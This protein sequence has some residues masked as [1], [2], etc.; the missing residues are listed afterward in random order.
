MHLL[1]QKGELKSRYA[2][3]KMGLEVEVV[4]GNCVGYCSSLKLEY[5][6]KTVVFLVK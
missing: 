3:L 2:Y 4:F 6:L 1:H 5:R